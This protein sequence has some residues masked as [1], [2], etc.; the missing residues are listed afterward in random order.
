[1]CVN[2]TTDLECMTCSNA[3]TC[4]SCNETQWLNP[5]T[6]DCKTAKVMCHPGEFWNE[7]VND[8]FACQDPCAECVDNATFCTK[9]MNESM[10]L[11]NGKCDIAKV[12]CT[13]GEWFDE[14]DNS[15]KMCMATC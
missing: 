1:M 7:T 6:S 4:D 12:N 9:C 15:C 14:S 13:E 3:T 5:N 2:C 10:W 11:D 8:C